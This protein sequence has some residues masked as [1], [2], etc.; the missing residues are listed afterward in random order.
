MAVKAFSPLTWQDGNMERPCTPVRH[1]SC[2]NGSEHCDTPHEHEIDLA[3]CSDLE[4]LA[5]GLPGL[6]GDAELRRLTERMQAASTRWARSTKTKK[7]Q[8][9]EPARECRL[10]DAIHAED[11]IDAIWNYWRA[12]APKDAERLAYMLRA[13]FDGRRRAIAIE[14]LA[15]G[16]SECQSSATD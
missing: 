11:V 15:L 7:I 9:V 12:P 10:L 8:I 16:C 14:R 2:A 6:P 5:D 3:M 13:L 1:P 4:A